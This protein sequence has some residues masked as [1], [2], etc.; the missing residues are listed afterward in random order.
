MK[1][2]IR[3]LGYAVI[4]LFCAGFAL[5]YVAVKIHDALAEHVD[6]P[7]PQSGI[8]FYGRTAQWTSAKSRVRT[9]TTLSS[10]RADR[11][12]TRISK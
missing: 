12:C 10:A 4:A 5:P 7:A 9:S 1:T 2:V 6:F 3:I 8:L 11:E